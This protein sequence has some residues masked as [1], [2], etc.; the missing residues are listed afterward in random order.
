LSKYFLADLNDS[1]SR[2]DTVSDGTCAASSTQCIWLTLTGSSIHVNAENLTCSSAQERR[3]TAAVT[4][5]NTSHV[6]E[7]ARLDCFWALIT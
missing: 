2:I 5:H 3:I 7:P 1:E 4:M 6:G